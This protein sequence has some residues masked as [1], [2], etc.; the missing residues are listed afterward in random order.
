MSN[1]SH[2]LNKR[3]LRGCSQSRRQRAPPRLPRRTQSRRQRS[4]LDC[5]DDHSHEDSDHLS[6]AAALTHAALLPM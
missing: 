2:T 4:P 1:A 5:Q 6:P 3:R